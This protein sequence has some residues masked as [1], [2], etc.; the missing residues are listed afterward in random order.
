MFVHGKSGAR[1]NASEHFQQCRA[2]NLAELEIETRMQL[3]S[4]AGPVDCAEFE[5]FERQL[6]DAIKRIRERAA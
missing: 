3:A 6:A 1:M 5:S 2:E 4:E